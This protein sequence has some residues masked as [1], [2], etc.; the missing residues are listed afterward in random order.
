MQ[1]NSM[2]SQPGAASEPAPRGLLATGQHESDE[3]VD[4]NDPAFQSAIAVVQEALYAN[5]AADAVAESLRA[6]QDP[7]KALA[8]T[9]YRMTQIADERTEGNVPDELLVLLGITVMQEVAEIGEASGVQYTGAD[10]AEAF[11]TMLMQFLTEQGY[12][13]TELQSALA[14]VDTGAFNSME[15]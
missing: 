4:E 3:T 15:N 11:K 2:T 14:Q 7:V 9:A 12:D 13:A 6:N 1:M 8:D 10:L 5:N